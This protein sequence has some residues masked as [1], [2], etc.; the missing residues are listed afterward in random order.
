V[1]MRSNDSNLINLRRL[2][3]GG[4]CCCIEQTVCHEPVHSWYRNAHNTVETREHLWQTPRTNAKCEIHFL[5]C[6]GLVREKEIKP[7][8]TGCNKTN[9]LREKQ[10]EKGW[11]PSISL[12]QHLTFWE[13]AGTVPLEDKQAPS[14][15]QRRTSG[16]AILELFHLPQ[17]QSS[18]R[19]KSLPAPPTQ[20]SGAPI[21]Y[22][23][24][25][26]AQCAGQEC[27]AISVMRLL[28]IAQ[29]PTITT[30]GQERFG[31][32]QT[33]WT[34]KA[35]SWNRVTSV[36]QPDS[37]PQCREVIKYGN[38]KRTVVDVALV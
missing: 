2:W 22:Q 1:W 8:R 4:Q 15:Q 36:S 14:Q 33:K 6:V 35:R 21:D 20:Y 30:A 32:A 25:I 29:L 13:L 10:K 3:I 17:G 12:S 19:S 38:R 5:L 9:M 24:E 16:S 26:Y 28:E 23:A 18:L 11:S 27:V 34:C 37:G 7:W 31:G